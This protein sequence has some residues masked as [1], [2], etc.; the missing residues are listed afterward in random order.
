MNYR[1]EEIFDGRLP[2]Y[3]VIKEDNTIVKAFD[4]IEEAEDYIFSLKT[5]PCG[6]ENPC[7]E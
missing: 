4:S 2:E 6:E 7:N 5:T 3:K 1:I